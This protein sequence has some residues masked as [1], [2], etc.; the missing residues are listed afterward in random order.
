[1]NKSQ[2]SAYMKAHRTEATLNLNKY[3]SR[4]PKRHKKALMFLTNQVLR[5]KI[6]NESLL[7][8]A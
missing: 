7:N 5:E 6:F 2:V 1:M 8:E 4:L 3:I